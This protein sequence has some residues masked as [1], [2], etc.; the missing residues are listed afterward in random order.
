MV[1]D[2]KLPDPER[3]GNYLYLTFGKQILLLAFNT[4]I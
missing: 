1:V 3:R 4:K 2:Q